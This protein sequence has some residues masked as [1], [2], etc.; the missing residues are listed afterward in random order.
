MLLL[1][2]TLPDL[3]DK[4][5]VLVAA[6][7][8]STRSLIGCETR[9][10]CCKNSLFIGPYKMTSIKAGESGFSFLKENKTSTSIVCFKDTARYYCWQ[11]FFQLKVINNVI[12]NKR[13]KQIL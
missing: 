13:N 10:W 6:N 8:K 12:E 9:K 7:V 3:I 5:S 11:S 4:I 2:T 1:F